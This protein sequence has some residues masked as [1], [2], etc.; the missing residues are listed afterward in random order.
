MLEKLI[1]AAILT[2]SLNLFVGL[3]KQSFTPASLGMNLQQTSTQ[4]ISQLPK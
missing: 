1:I 4:T 3:S 2:L